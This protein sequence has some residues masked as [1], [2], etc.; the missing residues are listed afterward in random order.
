MFDGVTASVVVCGH[1]HMQV[2]RQLGRMRIVNAGSVGMP[3]D[4][5]G[6]YW[7]Q[8]GPVVDLKHVAYDFAAAAERVR[9]TSH[10]QAAEFAERHIVAPPSREEMLDAF[11]GG[12]ARARST[13]ETR[14]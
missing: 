2:D 10:P 6:A 9:G 5:P 14:A 7:L 13:A 8:L 11:S 12:V 1:T 3:F 4:A